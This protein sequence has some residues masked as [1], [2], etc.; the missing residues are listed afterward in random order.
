MML[1]KGNYMRLFILSIICGAIFL[2]GCASSQI[3]STPVK[4]VSDEMFEG[5]WE[6][7]PTGKLKVVIK[8]TFLPNYNCHI[9]IDNKYRKDGYDSYGIYSLSQGSVIATFVKNEFTS[10]DQLTPI[11]KLFK[12]QLLRVI[13]KDK[14]GKLVVKTQFPTF[15]P[16]TLH[17]VTSIQNILS[18]VHS[19][20]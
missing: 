10:V 12:L 13:H 18:K 7:N 5:T 1:G 6:S 20:L 8:F 16:Y 17:Q 4:G 11:G 9:V 3:P 14:N 15:G 2:S 19:K